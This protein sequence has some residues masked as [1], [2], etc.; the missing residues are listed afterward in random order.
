MN[1]TIGILGFLAAR[2]GSTPEGTSDALERLE[3]QP[4]GVAALLVIALGLLAYGIWRLAAA[5]W[6]LEA[7][8]TEAKGMIARAGQTVTGVIHIGLAAVA[9][10]VVFGSGGSGGGSSIEDWTAR[11]MGWPFGQ[12]IVGIAGAIAAAAGLYYIYKGISEKY[13]RMLRSKP[14][15]L[16]L[17]PLLT[18]GLAAQGVVITIIGGLL[19]Y[20][21]WTTNPQEAGGLGDAFT[22][23]RDQP[24]GLWL[25][26]ALSLGL[27]AFCVFCLVNAAYRIIPRLGTDDVETLASKIEAK[28]KSA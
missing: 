19:V 1:L 14:L 28:A 25:V 12:W 6:D 13:M 27:C 21:A 10:A 18:A 15:T 26:M 22:W 3:G 11:I 24:Y 2:S 7:Y 8:G 17:R 20:A 23:L 9:A 5:F 4:W 16:R